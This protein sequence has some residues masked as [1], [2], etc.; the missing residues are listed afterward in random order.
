MKIDSSRFGSIEIPDDNVIALPQ[1]LIG[2]AGTRYALIAQSEGSPFLWLHSVDDGGLAVPVTNPWLFFPEYEVRLSDDD[3]AQLELEGPEQADILC[4]VCAAEDLA[5]FTVNLLSPVVV[6]GER[7][8]ARQVINE[9]S[10]YGVREPL[11]SEVELG[12][13]G[14]AEPQAPVVSK[15][16]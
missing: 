6:N 11:F 2:L 12:E 13:A 1:G 3:A 5:G 14:T 16:A 10:G 15:V 8:L 7:R 4:I 9:A